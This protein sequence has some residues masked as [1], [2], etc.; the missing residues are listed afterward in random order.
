MLK[1]DKQEKQREGTRSSVSLLLSEPSFSETVLRF[2]P[3][4]QGEEPG[5]RGTGNGA[6]QQTRRLRPGQVAMLPQ[7]IGNRVEDGV[8]GD[9]EEPERPGWFVLKHCY[10]CDGWPEKAL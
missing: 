1:C 3:T 10:Q 6:F 8:G 9:P 2:V 5:Q 7:E 4:P